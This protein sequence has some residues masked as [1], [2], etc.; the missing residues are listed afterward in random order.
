MSKFHQILEIFLVTRSDNTARK[1]RAY[2]REWCEFTNANLATSADVWRYISLL[3]KQRGIN[4][5][6]DN[7]LA[8]NTII[9]KFV[10]LRKFYNHLLLVSAVK[11]N[12]FHGVE[13]PK[14]HDEPQKRPT[15]AIPFDFVSKIIAATGSLTKQ[16]IRDKA[17]LCSFFGAGL[18][19]SEVQKLLIKDYRITPNGTRYFHL[20]KTKNRKNGEQA[21]PEWA[22]KEIT[23]HYNNRIA[24]G[25]NPN[26]PLWPIYIGKNED[27]TT[28]LS[29]STI[30]RLFKYYCR[31]CGLSESNFSVHSARATATTKLRTDGASKE[32]AQQ[33]LRHSS[34]KMV[35]IYDK[36]QNGIEEQIAKKVKY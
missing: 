7:N 18:R 32:E 12:P 2:W 31:I 16:S 3:K 17:I 14:K 27:P 30:Q 15:K 20:N 9:H 34:T 25:A 1:Y 23:E 35:D 26:E 4:V 11:S 6:D 28:G 24:D 8:W 19:L 10:M 21:L 33:F 36:R 29:T 5:A 13:I 22:A